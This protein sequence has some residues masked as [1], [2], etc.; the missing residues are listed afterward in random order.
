MDPFQQACARKMW[1]TCAIWDITLAVGHM[2]GESPTDTADA[3]SGWHLGQMY[4]DRV[5]VLVKDRG[6]DC[7][8]CM[9]IV[10]P[11]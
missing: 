5:S 6:S 3:L 2:A 7:S 1:L 10:S 8:Q 9:K 11:L 4:M